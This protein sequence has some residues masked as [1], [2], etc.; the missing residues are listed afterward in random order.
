MSDTPLTDKLKRK[1][2]GVYISPVDDSRLLQWGSEYLE[3]ARRLERHANAMAEAL[4]EC[5]D[6]AKQGVFVDHDCPAMFA[7]SA[8]VVETE[9]P[10]AA[11]RAFV[12][13]NS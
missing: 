5:E 6:Q 1:Q 11:W 3:L 4:K 13:E 8:I 2:E 12:K 9:Q 10:L 7:C